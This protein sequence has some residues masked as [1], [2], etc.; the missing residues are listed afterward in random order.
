MPLCVCWLE[1]IFVEPRFV[2]S[3]AGIVLVLTRKLA[4]G[5]AGGFRFSAHRA[6][7]FDCPT[8]EVLTCH[9]ASQI[10]PPS[11]RSVT[12]RQRPLP[13]NS[14]SLPDRR[15]LV[16]SASKR[17]VRDVAPLPLLLWSVRLLIVTGCVSG[18]P[19]HRRTCFRRRS[20]RH[21]Y[22]GSVELSTGNPRD[23]TQSRIR[24][25]RTPPLSS[26]AAK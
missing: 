22:H 13:Q 1:H 4:R 20:A 6:W 12:L 5:L 17:R 11:L 21:R 19:R 10:F 7:S 2:A 23:A 15:S 3:D 8:D 25:A 14:V 9:S 16:L 24:S 26:M 18:I